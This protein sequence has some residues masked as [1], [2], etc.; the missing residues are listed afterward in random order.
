MHT[1]IHLGILLLLTLAFVAL[2]PDNRVY[3]SLACALV[4]NAAVC[5][6][7]AWWQA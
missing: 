5:C 4:A 6:R 7:S 2:L 1:N 3:C